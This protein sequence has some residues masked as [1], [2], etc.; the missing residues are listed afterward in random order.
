M[1]E[2][3][4]NPHGVDYYKQY[5]KDTK[6]KSFH[7]SEL[8]D[9]KKIKIDNTTN[10][11]DRI[12]DANYAPTYLVSEVRQSIL[13]SIYQ[14][15]FGRYMD[16]N[17]ESAGIGYISL[18]IND[19]NLLSPL[20][21]LLP[22]T[23][24]LKDFLNAYIRVL[25]D[26]YRFDDPDSQFELSLVDEYSKFSTSLR[27]PI[28][29][30]SIQNNIK[31][32][33]LGNSLY[34]VLSK[35]C[36]VNIKLNPNHLQFTVV[37]KQSGYYKC[38]NCGKIHLHKGMGICTNT[39][40]IDDLPQT[41]TGTVDQIHRSHFISFD[42]LIEKRK[43][44]RL[45]TEELTGQTDNQA[46]RQ[47]EFKGIIVSNNQ[48]QDAEKL[49][50]EIDMINV[51][52]TMEVGVDIGSLEAIYQGN[53]PPTRYNY[54]Q[55]VG[56]GGRRGQ[57]YSAAVTFCRGKS[58][59]TYYYY[60]ATDEMV[61]SI[62]VAPRL[63]IAPLSDGNNWTIKIP[64]V[65]RMLTKNILKFAFIEILPKINN[66][67]TENY[68]DTHGEFGHVEQWDEIKPKLE[69]WVNDN[70][71]LIDRYVHKYLDQFNQNNYIDSNIAFLS[72]WFKNCLV[73]NL[74]SAVDQK[75]NNAGL[76]E[77]FAE[78]GFL[79]MF[80]MPSNQRVLYHGVDK[81]HKIVKQIDRPLEQSITEFAPGS[82]KTKD[83][84]FYE[85]AGLT[86]PL[87]Y[88][89]IGHNRDGIKTLDRYDP[90]NNNATKFDALEY[91]F[92]ITINEDDKS[93]QSIGS[94][95]EDL[96][97][98]TTVKRLVIPKAFRT[99]KIEGNQGSKSENSDSKNNFTS[100]SLFAN[101]D[102]NS[103]Q[104]QINNCKINLFGIT[105]NS[106]GEIWHVNDNNGNYFKGKSTHNFR[107]INNEWHNGPVIIGAQQLTLNP[108]FIIEKYLSVPNNES[109]HGDIALGSR[110]VTELLKLEINSIPD[111]INLSIHSGNSSAIKSAFYSA[112]YI[113]QRVLADKLD[114]QPSEIE[115]S[116]LKINENGIPIIY[117]SDALANGAGFVSYLFE[118][119]NFVEMISSIVNFENNFIK[120]LIDDQHFNECKT[121]CQKCLNSY[122]NS[123][124]HHIL[125]WRLGIGLLRLMIN[126]NFR[127][128]IDQDLQYADLNDLIE[129]MNSVSN[130]ISSSNPLSYELKN[131]EYGLAYIK[132]IPASSFDDFNHFIVHPLWNKDY[133]VNNSNGFNPGVTINEYNNYFDIL[134]TNKI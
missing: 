89:N 39:Q 4:I 45:H 116:E 27:N 26:H 72:D 20:K 119:D 132:N 88:G 94:F 83:K 107:D 28:R 34:E 9:F 130:M 65:R 73:Q 96:L 133:L 47:L 100:S 103:S 2:L 33:D 70:H 125:D 92:N 57:A 13:V 7:W 99:V 52:T 8:Y 56:R 19:D 17:T 79:P 67:N 76:A 77:I 31:E 44:K 113:L 85:S 82:I 111:E 36:G 86:I 109:F 123:G 53:M 127:F 124:Y 118:G 42:L 23:I 68:S 131:G 16:L 105:D 22:P 80:G 134:R 115:I 30:I 24:D 63:T 43:A 122:D 1:L 48:R 102:G 55:R 11:Q 49:S 61:G 114:I 121:S 10:I 5:P 87:N 6:N 66:D 69:T 50:K 12:G 110:K 37:D 93:I 97:S 101:T 128:G 62:A 81:R 51:T 108:N 38:P 98:E 58:H 35:L 126:E 129:T 117:L 14:N 40:C 21:G 84:G 71:N 41:R 29:K 54:Q 112:A 18:L 25:G 74:Q 15:S 59:D 78:A 46:E 106:N 104:R 64:I 32:S 90:K 60:K 95:N 3:G 91:S 120:S 75:T